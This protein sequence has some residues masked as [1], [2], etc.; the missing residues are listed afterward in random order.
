[1]KTQILILGL[2]LLTAPALR[3][4]DVNFESSNLPIVVIDTHGQT[5]PDE[6]RI[7]ADM[8][9]IYN[10]PGQRN[11]IN[12]PFNN[13][14]GKISI[15]LRGSSSQMFPKKQ[16]ALETED[17]QGE[18]LNVS[19]LGLPEEND[20]ILNGPYSD[21]SLIRNV[22]IYRL[23]RDLGH[24]ASRT[25]FGELVLNGDYRGVYILM[26]KIKR[27]KHRVHI[28]KLKPDEVSGDDL[29][30]GYIVKIDKLAGE[31]VDGW[32]SIFPPYPTSTH[33]IYYQYHY[34]KPDKI[35]DEQKQY[36]QNYI[37]DFEKTMFSPDYQDQQKGYYS[38]VD[39]N[40]FVDYFLLNEI[41]RNV[42]GYRLSAYLYKDKDSNDP[43]LHAGPIWDFNIAFGNAD[44]YHAYST[45]GWQV[46]INHDEQFISWDDPF[47][48]PF[49]WEKLV[50]D[51]VFMKRVIKRWKALRPN[52][53][54]KERLFALIDSYADTLNEAQA[55]NFE[56]WPVLGT[57]V[58]PNYFVGNTYQEEIDYLK[59]WIDKRLQWMDTQLLD[60]QPPS[61]P[62]N[63]QASEITS[64]SV[65]L[66]WS[67]A[68]DNVGVAGYDVFLNGK[69]VA[70]STKLS[71][72]VLNLA[73]ETDYT[74]T[75][76]AR[77]F[78]GNYSQNNPQIQVTTKAFTSND[79]VYCPAVTSPIKIDGFPEA[80]WD[81][82]E[83]HDIDH[84]IQGKVDNPDDLS[85]KF[86]VL[87][88]YEN[89]YL[90][91]RV[92]DDAKVRDSN[93]DYY[94]DDDLEVYLDLDN[95][96]HDYYDA[97]DFRY[98]FTYQDSLIVEKAQ[99][100]TQGVHSGIQMLNDGYRIEINFPWNTLTGEAV[101]EKVIGFE[102]QLNDDDDG[103]NRDAKLAWWGTTDIAYSDPSAFGTLK[104][105]GNPTGLIAISK[106][107]ENFIL[108]RNRPNPF[109]GSTRIV[110]TLKKA[111]QITLQVFD[112]NGRLMR[113]LISNKT[114]T[115]GRHEVLLYADH[116][117]S[118]LYFYRL[119]GNKEKREVSGRML[120]L[121]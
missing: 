11:H 55:R 67:A 49:W 87:W 99:H 83:W 1:M 58:W 111:D 24:Y 91:V 26:E 27:D 8:G 34:P 9:I 44:Y 84:L 73:D 40:S 14:N 97:D 96:K 66:S 41:S 5:I 33:R 60:S 32:Y 114:L 103:G 95:S 116:W 77:D 92:Y 72:E 29:T 113:T 12:D 90:L 35:V 48:I 47:Q 121:K 119:I 56:R 79:G 45:E 100:A 71:T 76:K 42:D 117:A 38:K 93:R 36:I 74:F 6:Y 30:G 63:L 108:M 120:L 86:K 89:L 21:K 68:S 46:F 110:F 7:M 88:D 115:A 69:R 107:P 112:L 4:G 65:L 25:R 102:V 17:A 64:Y 82:A 80:L 52:L 106:Q 37:F 78:A 3:A 20:W 75:V 19:L 105:K 22:L 10:G 94:Q 16:Y 15:E 43:R 85:A 13:Y 39:L 70:G 28:A 104:L 98:R 57:H 101:P 53:L 31:N 81:K 62:T 51:S 61:V 18:N 2:L 118:G 109:N 59:S 50:A 54:S 23:A